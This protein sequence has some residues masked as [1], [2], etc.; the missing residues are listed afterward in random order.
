MTIR[1][2]GAPHRYVQGPGALAELA[3]LVP[4]YGKRVFVVADAI[5]AGLLKD[6]IVAAIGAGAEAVTFGEFGGECSGT[7]IDRMTAAA[8]AAQADVV[9][10]LGGGK[11][12]DT[13][14]GVRMARGCGL[15]IV[16]TIASNDS[17]TSRLV[18]VYTPDHAVEG[19]RL[20]ATNPDAV[21]VDTEVIVQAPAR[22]FLAGIGDALTKKF[23]AEQCYRTGGLN[24]YKGR[25]PELALAI[26]DRCYAIIREKALP[27]LAAVQAKKTDEAVESVV[28][29]TI[30]M[31]GLG[32]ENGGL[33]IAH[34]LTRGFSAIAS[35][36]KALHGEQVA[37]GLLVQL[38]MEG[39]S[40]DFVEE[41]RQ[42][43]RQLGLPLSLADLGLTG[44]KAEAIARIAQRSFAEAP[45]I[46][47]IEAEVDEQVIV[48]AIETLEAMG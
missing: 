2:F 42:F 7:E 13:A 34:S 46:R 10:G 1:T 24:F 6:R 11:A 8:K 44:D 16:P 17:P 39:R 37:Y 23:E 15:I 38:V 45:Y 3:A 40:A 47:H 33:S 27:A 28:E 31:S 25:P 22:F 36:G 35:L 30:L 5:V 18:V 14:K 4:Q 29:A 41:L 12:I 32:F 21:L 26:A 43:Y 20:M 9:I 48:S 19:V